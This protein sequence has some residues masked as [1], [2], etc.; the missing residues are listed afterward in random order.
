MVVV[1]AIVIIINIVSTGLGST[2]GSQIDNVRDNIIIPGLV[3]ML[4]G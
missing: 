1:G 3:G 4:L 2:V